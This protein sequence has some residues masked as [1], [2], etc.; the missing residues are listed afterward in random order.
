MQKKK[1]RELRSFEISHLEEQRAKRKRVK[2]AYRPMVPCKEKVD[3][4][5]EVPKGEERE[6]GI[7]SL[8]E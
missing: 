3:M 1:I 8:F 6:K 2:K 4:Y 5:Y 7:E